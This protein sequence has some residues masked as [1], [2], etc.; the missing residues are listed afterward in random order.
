MQHSNKIKTARGRAYISYTTSGCCC[1]YRNKARFDRILYNTNDLYA[2][3]LAIFKI[4]KR[5]RNN[6]LGDD[7][8]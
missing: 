8:E 6:K 7:I 4:P 3:P 1:C 5:K 2:I